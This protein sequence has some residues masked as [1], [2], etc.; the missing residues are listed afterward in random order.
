MKLREIFLLGHHKFCLRETFFASTASEYKY[1]YSQ[2]HVAVRATEYL[3]KSSRQVATDSLL[4]GSVGTGRGKIGP[5]FIV[6]LTTR[7]E[8][9]ALVVCLIVVCRQV[10]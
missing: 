9:L 2:S 7:S 1:K 3:A 8:L 5:E 4:N 10:H 6:M